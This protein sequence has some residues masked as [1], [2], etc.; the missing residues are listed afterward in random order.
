MPLLYR[1]PSGLLL[2]AGYVVINSFFRV[3]ES[4]TNKEKKRKGSQLQ[5][6]ALLP[7]IFSPAG[8]LYPIIKM[9]HVNTKTEKI[10]KANVLEISAHRSRCPG[11][12]RWCQLISQNSGPP[13]ELRNT[14]QALAE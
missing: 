1:E 10:P 14:V 11:G 3:H 5:D 2:L 13:A 12:G 9:D 8:E 4:V 6:S 7:C